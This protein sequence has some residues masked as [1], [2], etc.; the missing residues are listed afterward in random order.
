MSEDGEVLAANDAFYAAFASGD[1][2][3][4]EAVWSRAAPVSCCHP[5]WE[6][7]LGRA[8]VMASFR[9][10]IGNG[11][12]PVRVSEASA[13]IVG[14]A[15]WVICVETLP[16]GRL[17]ATNLFVREA[18]RYRLV[19]HHAGPIAPSQRGGPHTPPTVF[20]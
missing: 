3:A 1:L 8:Q 15:A 19:L 18:G 7:L 12:P 17:A 20:N 2:D 9:A 4:M 10:I 13:H 16:T 6:P 14:D 11:P 5:G